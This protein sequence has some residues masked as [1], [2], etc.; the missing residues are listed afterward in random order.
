MLTLDESIPSFSDLYLQGQ[1]IFWEQFNEVNFYVEDTELEQLYFQ[2]LK[3]IFPNI[4][5][6]K[7]FPLN[8]KKNVI[9]DAKA[10]RNNKKRI[11]IVDKDFDDLHGRIELI[12]NLFYLDHYC[13]ENYLFEEI[14][15]LEFVV[16]ENPKIKQHEFTQKYHLSERIS[17]ILEKLIY[18]NS[19]HFIVQK[20]GLPFEN[21]SLHID[22]FLQK[23]KIEICQNKLRLYKEKLQ[24]YI[25]QNNLTID[26]EN[27]IVNNIKE[28]KAQ[29]I[30]EK[31][32][33]GKHILF[34]LLHDLK[35]EFSIKKLPDHYSACY[36]LAKE[37]RFESLHFL[38]QNIL[39][40]WN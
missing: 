20:L 12:D 9:E 11:Y 10:N 26:L 28:W 23:N 40:F 17:I 29:E 34:I 13:I 27:T 24:Q 3:K 22:C 33:C 19:L 31:N 4:K 2:I 1:D 21:S 7:I 32:I 38:R 14:S 16:S 18:I 6:E 39:E 5:I 37:C 35:K 30:I 25:V 8:G 15:I 36:R